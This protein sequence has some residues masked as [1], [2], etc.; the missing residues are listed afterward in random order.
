[1]TFLKLTC[2][3]FAHFLT[4]NN[5]YRH[6]LNIRSY[7]NTEQGLNASETSYLLLL[8]LEKAEGRK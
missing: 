3:P 6:L 1:M 8:S 4:F 2:L 5:S 7:D